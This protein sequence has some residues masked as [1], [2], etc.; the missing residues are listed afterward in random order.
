MKH[1]RW[2]PRLLALALLAYWFVPTT[3][4]HIR[5]TFDPFTFNDDARILI[6]PFFREADPSLFQGDPFAAYFRAG[7]PEGYLA[8][9]RL[10]GSLG[11]AK[12]ASEILPY[13]LLFVTLGFVVVTAKR[14]GGGVG[15]WVSA[16]LL[17]G[18]VS[19]YDRLGGGLPRAF[20]FPI[21]AA[22]A[23]ALVSARPR[24]LALLTVLGAA[25]Y[26]VVAA[27]L[28][29]ALFFLL[30][31]PS[32]LRCVDTT[33]S[34][35]PRTHELPRLQA[36]TR[37]AATSFSRFTDL[38]SWTGRLALLVV[39][40][41]AIVLVLVPTTL[42]LR[43]YGEPITRDL[44][45][46]YPEAGPGGRLG[47]EQQA[48]F[49]PWYKSAGFHAKQALLGSGE[50][51]GGRPALALRRSP[52]REQLA[53]G[54]VASLA[55]FAL[56]LGAVLRRSMRPELV[57]LAALFAS[58]IVGYVLSALVTPRLF[59]P[60]RYAQYAAPIL[61]F[62]LV[63]AGFGELRRREGATS[64]SSR[65]GPPLVGVSLALLV[66]LL[67][68]G[69][70]T[71]WVGI[72]VWIPTEERPLYGALAELPKDSV[73]AGFPQGPLENVPYLSE[74][75]VLTNYQLEMPFHRRFCDESRRRVRALFDAYFA[76]D[77]APIARLSRDFGVT[78]L[79]VDPE[80]FGAVMPTYYRPFDVEVWQRYTASKG[81]ATVLALASDPRASRRVGRFS[82]VDLRR[83]LDDTST[84]DPK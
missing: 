10:F 34:G 73:I 49:P 61:A 67:V 15:A 9:Y 33:Q 8:L 77:L 74:R 72:E 58:M 84:Q 76:T 14:L 75:R 48:P 35:H 43:P 27:L 66:V 25:F 69:R 31:L 53:A 46:L 26:P 42:R 20:A 37:R 54:F 6:W 17:L 70:G 59:L 28:G 52:G 62:L 40:F 22:G 29:L 7:L 36:E 38:S 71:S 63:A 79:V 44:L 16:V 23:Y 39:T 13:L 18:S 64:R 3:V 24:L 82:I 51:L 56:G 21:V 68:G 41:I 81:R 47:P 4:N 83:A 2:I 30:V 1:G 32:R 12:S 45:S 65:F 50:P 57:R 55:V 78:H 80:H 11:L 60:E 19:V 5:R